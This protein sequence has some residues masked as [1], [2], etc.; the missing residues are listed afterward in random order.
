MG[1]STGV[2]A[3]LGWVLSPC[4]SNP[5]GAAVLFTGCLL[6]RECVV[7]GDP[8]GRRCRRK[9]PRQRPRN[10]SFCTLFTL[11]EAQGTEPQHSLRL[12]GINLKHLI[13]SKRSHQRLN[14]HNL[15]EGMIIDLVK[16]R[17]KGKLN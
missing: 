3:R 9:P 11:P 14:K 17:K 10:H 5:R 12:G 2:T 16:K 4:G 13:A 1:P 6:P 8:T 7:G 15:T